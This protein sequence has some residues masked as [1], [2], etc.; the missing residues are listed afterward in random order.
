LNSNSGPEIPPEEPETETSPIPALTGTISLI[1]VS[2]KP[3][4]VDF[5]PLTYTLIEEGSKPNPLPLTVNVSPLCPEVGL[6]DVITPSKLSISRGLLSLRHAIKM[7]THRKINCLIHS[8]YI[9]KLKKSSI[10]L[11]DYFCPN[12]WE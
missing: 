4:I 5:L 2:L 11:L 7:K 6:M 1:S 12:G 3:T 10:R 8:K 9:I